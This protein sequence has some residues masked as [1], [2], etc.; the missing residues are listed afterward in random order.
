MW[1]TQESPKQDQKKAPVRSSHP[2]K[3]HLEPT[4]E[5]QKDLY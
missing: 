1:L 5:P 2:G 3:S 4:L